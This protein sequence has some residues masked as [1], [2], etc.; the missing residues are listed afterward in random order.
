ML[1]ETCSYT[2]TTSYHPVSELGAVVRTAKLGLGVSDALEDLH[3][4]E[5]HCLC[6]IT[7][8]HANR[9]SLCWI[10]LMVKVCS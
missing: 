9:V 3:R 1:V 5:L 4:L 7:R 2:M 6:W 10:R 8:P